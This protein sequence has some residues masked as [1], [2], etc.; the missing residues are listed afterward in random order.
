MTATV[1]TSEI[2]W[3]PP[4]NIDFGF[5]GLDRK[6]AL[7]IIRDLIRTGWPELRRDGQCVYV[8]RITGDV[9][10]HYPRRHSPVIYI[11]EGKAY[12]RVSEHAGKW[13]VDLVS[14]I[15]QVGVSIRIAEAR[16]RNREDFY[17]DVEADLLRI[18][19]ERF[20]TLPWF[21]RQGERSREGRLEYDEDAM[22]ELRTQL[23]VGKGNTVRWA[24]RPTKNHDRYADYLKGE[25]ADD[26]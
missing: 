19:R 13:L 15:P 20:G 8:V 3:Q 23:G 11:G 9:A 12:S 5:S 1:T 18:F 7:T 25:P 24:I 22:R 2:Q 21:N 4:V 10:I 14:A 26:D 16:R 17:K 6:Y